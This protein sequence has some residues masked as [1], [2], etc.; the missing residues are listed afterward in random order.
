MRDAKSITHMT[1][2]SSELE[3]I[4]NVRIS[5]PLVRSDRIRGDGRWSDYDVLQVRFLNDFV[6]LTKYELSNLLVLL[7]I[8]PRFAGNSPSLPLGLLRRRRLVVP[9]ARSTRGG[10]WWRRRRR[11]RW[12]RR[13]P[14]RRRPSPRRLRARRS[15]FGTLSCD[16]RATYPQLFLSSL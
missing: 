13:G 3:H 10:R 14:R 6:S 5:V 2:K 15:R 9:R 8:E 7:I 16:A 12:C 1:G 4:L 11:W